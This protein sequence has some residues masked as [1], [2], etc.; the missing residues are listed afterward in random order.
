M[1]M[2]HS[3]ATCSAVRARRRA[4]SARGG[5]RGAVP[6]EIAVRRHSKPARPHSSRSRSTSSRRSTSPSQR[7][8]HQRRTRSPAQ[9]RGRRRTR[10][11]AGA[12][13]E[14]RPG[15][16]RRAL[17]QRRR[18]AVDVGDHRHA[19]ERRREV[20]ASPD[21]ARIRA[22]RSSRWV[23]GPAQRAHRRQLDGVAP[24][25]V[26]VVGA[27]GHGRPSK[28]PG[29]RLSVARHAGAAR[30]GWTPPADGTRYSTRTAIDTGQRVGDVGRET[31]FT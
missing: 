15:G 22:S 26:V 13:A 19:L 20:G 6:A 9:W 18:D 12:P 16:L 11:H 28:R 27:D 24:R 2:L 10:A 8:D 1:A 30:P 14:E 23:V 31:H 29:A 7:R 5:L 25:R 21:V 4:P 17:D 3:R